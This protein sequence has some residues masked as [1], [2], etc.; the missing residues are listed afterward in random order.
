MIK[1]Q[2]KTGTKSVDTITFDHIDQKFEILG[3]VIHRHDFHHGIRIGDG[4]RLGGGNDN[5]V[6]GG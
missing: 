1:N 4:G 2:R 6:I 3:P 5:T